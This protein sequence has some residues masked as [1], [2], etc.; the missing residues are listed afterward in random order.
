VFHASRFLEV[1]P[2]VAGKR[3]AVIGAGQTGAELV[4]HL[5]NRADRPAQLSW[6]ARRCNFLPLDDSAFANEYFLPRYSDHFF[7]LPAERRRALLLEQALASDGVNNDLLAR[8]YRRLYAI[9]FVEGA[10]RPCRLLPAHSFDELRPDGD[11][12]R[13][14]LKDLNHGR[15]AEVAADIV[16]LSTGFEY[17]APDCFAPLLGRIERDAD[18]FVF[19]EDFSVRWDGP[20]NR[21]V[22][23]QNG[24]R[25]V[26][27]IADPNLSLM[28]WR[29]ALILNAVAGRVVYDVADE[30]SAV[31]W[32]R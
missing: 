9:E 27:G 12:F 23:I 25:H 15:A 28:C 21:R 19:N 4:D 32:P 22:F 24:A 31:D 2:D 10:G 20:A 8:I 1:M 7:A 17:K 11:G 13:L 3:V 18:G 14:G 30:S 6:I 5:L 16:I 26:R 29:N